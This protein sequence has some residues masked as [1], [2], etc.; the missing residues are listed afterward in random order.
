MSL[1]LGIDPG[2]LKTGYG[3]IKVEGSTLKHVDNGVIWLN[4]EKDITQRVKK[5][6]FKIKEL[7]EQFKPQEVAIEKIFYAKNVKSLLHLGEA[8][9]AAIVA[10]LTCGLQVS[11]YSALEVKKA[12]VGY[13]KA[14]KEQVQRMM[15]MLLNLKEN[16]LEDAADALAVAM[17]HF[18]IS[19]Y[20]K[21]ISQA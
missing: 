8:R 2:S 16:P 1:I 5:I 18:Q 20:R 7:L 15:R 4:S 17:C 21:R 3:L 12:V 10:A 13:G 6:Y 14:P 9:G 19:Q 11:E